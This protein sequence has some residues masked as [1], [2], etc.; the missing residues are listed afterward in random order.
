M[1]LSTWPKCVQHDS[2]EQVPKA[3]ETERD[4]EFRYDPARLT[5]HWPKNGGS[6]I[7]SQ[8]YLLRGR[9]TIKAFN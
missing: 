5:I 6:L 1:H 2:P 4:G 3:V 8:P 9:T 7:Y